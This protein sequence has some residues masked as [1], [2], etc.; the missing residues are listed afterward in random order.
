MG[1]A[2]DP[3]GEPLRGALVEGPRS[4]ADSEDR[5]LVPKSAE[6]AAM[7]G[8]TV[9]AAEVD[10]GVGVAGSVCG[11]GGYVR[12]GYQ[13]FGGEREHRG[14]RDSAGHLVRC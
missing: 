10:E 1:S 4:P 12:I 2:P 14:V 11:L 8:G 6:G 7:V 13:G 3:E 5:A 9:P